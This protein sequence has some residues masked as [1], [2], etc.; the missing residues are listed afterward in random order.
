MSTAPKIET[1]PQRMVEVAP[2]RF[3]QL[4][5][6]FEVPE[7]VLCDVVPIQGTPGAYRLVPNSWEKLERVNWELCLKLGLGNDTTT[8]RRLIRSGF[9][10]G[11]RVSP[12]VYTVNLASYFNH[13]KR[14]S[15]DPDF[16]EN[17][18]VRDEYNT[19]Y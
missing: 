18:K 19:A 15:D 1:P 13:L 5:L 10:D 16:W 9:V 7:K 2:N 12:Q 17:P 8:L 4:D 14:C 11:A 3:V 6:K